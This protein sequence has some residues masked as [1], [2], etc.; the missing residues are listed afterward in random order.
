MDDFELYRHKPGR[1]PQS[2]A[3]ATIQKGGYLTLSEPAY[4]MLDRP[5]AVELLFSQEQQAIGLRAGD[6]SPYGFKLKQHPTGHIYRVS[7]TRGFMAR[8]GIPTDKARRFPATWDAE[9]KM[10]VID[11]S[12]PGEPVIRGGI[13]SQD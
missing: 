10:L 8:Y 3:T 11:V 4:N 12:G 7:S 2:E 6:N 5:A 9:H 13:A 1:K